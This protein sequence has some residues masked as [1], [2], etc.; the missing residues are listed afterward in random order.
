MRVTW[1]NTYAASTALTAATLTATIQ[2]NLSSL[3][4]TTFDTLGAGGAAQSAANPYGFIYWLSFAN[5]DPATVATS[6]FDFWVGRIQFLVQTT[7]T[8]RTANDSLTY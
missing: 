5:P 4:L 1:G 6:P 7:T 3:M 8:P 2:L